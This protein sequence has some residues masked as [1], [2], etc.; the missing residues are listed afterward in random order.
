[1]QKYSMNE[2][3]LKLA[4]YISCTGWLM[5]QMV[6]KRNSDSSCSPAFF[7]L[8]VNFSEVTEALIRL[9][10]YPYFLL[11]GMGQQVNI[12]TVLFT[13]SVVCPSVLNSVCLI[14]NWLVPSQS[15]DDPYT[16][17]S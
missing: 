5:H 2:S 13:F 15:I 7:K 16:L 3:N 12:T 9:C 17:S 11:M 1:M 10:S 6:A 8:D 14:L 4:T